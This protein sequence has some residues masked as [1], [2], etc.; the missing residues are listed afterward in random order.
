MKPD[1]KR[2][3]SFPEEKEKNS[4]NKIFQNDFQSLKYYFYPQNKNSIVFKI[5]SS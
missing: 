3:V 5:K 4:K 1:K 2:R